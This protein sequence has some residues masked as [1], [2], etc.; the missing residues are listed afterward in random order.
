M[1]AIGLKQALRGRF[2]F[3]SI[4]YFLSGGKP[5]HSPKSLSSLFFVKIIFHQ[6]SNILRG[7]LLKDELFNLLDLLD[8]KPR[9]EGR[10]EALNN[11]KGVEIRSGQFGT[12]NRSVVLAYQNLYG[13]VSHSEYKTNCQQHQ[14]PKL[15]ISCQ[16]GDLIIQG[17]YCRY[18]NGTLT[19]RE[20]QS[21]DG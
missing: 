1:P 15:N 16:Q 13:E 11:Q 3:S 18:A 5:Y 6:L 8:K 21:K 9:I 19:L 20:K 12:E 2:L 4:N 17:I 14:H 10:K 7:L